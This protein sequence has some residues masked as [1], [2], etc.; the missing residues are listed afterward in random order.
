[1][2]DLNPASPVVLGT[3]ARELGKRESALEF[4]RL[5]EAGDAATQGHRLLAACVSV[6]ELRRCLLQ[7]PGGEGRRFGVH[8]RQHDGKLVA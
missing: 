8:M 4:I 2:I 7:G 1:M 5:T 3:L 6:R